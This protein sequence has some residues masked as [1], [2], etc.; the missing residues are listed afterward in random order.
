MSMNMRR[1]QLTKAHQKYEKFL[2]LLW[3]RFL[4][5]DRDKSITLTWNQFK[6]YELSITD[7]AQCA[8]LLQRRSLIKGWVYTGEQE[9]E[10]N[11]LLEINFWDAANEHPQLMTH[12]VKFNIEI[13]DESKLL[14][15]IN[16]FQKRTRQLEKV[17]LVLYKDNYLCLAQSDSKSFCYLLRQRGSKKTQRQKILELLRQNHAPLSAERIAQMLK[18]TAKIIGKEIP[19]MFEEIAKKLDIDPG[20]IYYSNDNGYRLVCN[21]ISSED[22]AP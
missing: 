6:E 14:T 18:S 2:Q 13:L 20:E 21:F 7:G 10:S 8:Y 4:L 15:H 5:G 19:T 9:L 1:Q 11:G 17:A 3:E 16:K 12:K 22:F